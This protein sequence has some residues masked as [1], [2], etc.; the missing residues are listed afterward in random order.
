MAKEKKSVL[1]ILDG[2]GFRT[3][4]ADNAIV[5]ANTPFYDQALKKYPFT[6]LMASES[7]V[8]LPQGVMGNSEVGHTNIGCGRRVTQDQVRI[9]DAIEDGS[10]YT[11]PVLLQAIETAK[12]A[13]K[14]IHVMGLVST[15]SVH[16]AQDHYFCLLDAIKRSNFEMNQCFFHAF[17]DGR[18]TPP[19]SAKTFIQPL[20]EKIQDVGAQMA[21]ISGRYYAMDRDQRWDRTQL[22]YQAIVHGKGRKAKTGLEAIEQSYQ[23]N[24][25]DEFVKPT[26]LVRE[27]QPVGLVEDDDVVICFNFRADRMRQLVRALGG[28]EH[29]MSIESAVKPNIITMTEYDATFNLPQMF[30]TIDLSMCLGEYLSSL[31]KK[32]FRIAETE[33][34]AHV[35]FFFNGGREDPFAHEHR[36]LIPSPKVATYDLT[37]AMNSK[38]VTQHL[39]KE[40]DSEKEDFLVV[41]FAQPDMVGHTGNWDAAIQAVEATDWAL[42]QITQHA[43]DHGYT[44]FLTADHGNI[45]MMKDPAT[46]QPHT[47]HTLA[48]VPLIMMS[49]DSK[50]YRLEEGGSLSNI[51]PTILTSMGIDIPTEMTAKNLLQS[52]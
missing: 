35:T 19:Q 1:I 20:E 50:G 23:E 3:E 24:V 11:N 41:N 25:F 6:T 21:S 37:P 13:N 9:Y 31:G 43:F 18:D 51:A 17:L 28:F 30:P 52:I 22:A 36:L 29:G 32:Q 42:S 16:S 49:K 44:V 34:Y 12:S 47:S 40:I 15:G 2:W 48:P 5:Q 26:V 45:E 14:K 38:L 7:Y 27:S 46:G 10:F 39:I 33:K 4:K 8:G